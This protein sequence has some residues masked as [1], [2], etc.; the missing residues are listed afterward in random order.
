MLP[1]AFA[2]HTPKEGEDWKEY[3]KEQS[4][5]QRHGVFS[6]GRLQILSLFSLEKIWAGYK[7]S[8]SLA[9]KR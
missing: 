4:A 6:E 1:A 9:W 8:D 2:C 3:R 7:D 5:G